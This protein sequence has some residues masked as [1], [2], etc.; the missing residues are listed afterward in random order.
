M[1]S[2]AGQHPRQLHVRRA[3]V[4]GGAASHPR[5]GRGRRP[6]GRAARHEL[7]ARPRRAERRRQPACV[8]AVGRHARAASSSPI[9][10]S[11]RTPSRSPRPTT[12][13]S[14]GI[15][16]VR[17]RR[18][19][20]PQR[21]PRP[22]RRCVP[23]LHTHWQGEA[24]GFVEA[25]WTSGDA[26]HLVMYLRAARRRRRALQHARSLPRSLRHGARPRLLPA[27]R[28]LLVGPARVLRAA[29]PLA[30]LGPRRRRLTP[31]PHH[32]NP[33]TTRRRRH[34]PTRTPTR[35]GERMELSREVQMDLH[36]RMVRI[37]LFE[38]AAGRLAESGE[39]ARLPPPLRRRGGR[40][41]RRVRER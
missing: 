13:S 21:V 6:V 9:R 14:S 10:R 17:D 18:R 32:R 3:T 8:P 24:T 11:S 1:R 20:V 15:E 16:S 23:L 37:R 29:A 7:R 35:R 4:R 25:D 34:D 2:P 27:R 12:G 31:S 5:V 41:R 39:A 33:T 36:R 22:R 28:T 30:A 26:E 40:R 19:A 38:E